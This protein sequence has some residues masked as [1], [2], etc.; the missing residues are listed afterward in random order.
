MREL[1]ETPKENQDYCKCCNAVVLKATLK[2]CRGVCRKCR[3]ERNQELSTYLVF[4]L[5][6]AFLIFVIIAFTYFPVVVLV[7]LGLHLVSWIIFTITLFRLPEGT[8]H[9]HFRR[10][11]A[12]I[13]FLYP[14]VGPITNYNLYVKP[15]KNR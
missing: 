12:F 7:I 5:Y 10:I 2:K 11:T 14:I 9:K 15:V 13:A 6:I 3:S 8:Y 1:K 4:F